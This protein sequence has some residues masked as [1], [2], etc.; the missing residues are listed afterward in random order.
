MEED[1]RDSSFLARLT[2]TAPDF[3][4]CWKKNAVLQDHFAIDS[5]TLPDRQKSDREK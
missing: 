3:N 5:A 2:R 4:G 1:K